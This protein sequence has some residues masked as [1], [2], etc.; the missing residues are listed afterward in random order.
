MIMYVT[1]IWNYILIDYIFSK[2]DK[3]GTGFVTDIHIFIKVLNDI[4]DERFPDTT[5][6][7]IY[8]GDSIKDVIMELREENI[9][10]R[11]SPYELFNKSVNYEDTIEQLV[12]KWESM[13]Y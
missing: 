13:L 3:G 9:K 8:A 6:Y 11:Y 2:P 5:R 12:K 1:S 10:L 7:I 4:M